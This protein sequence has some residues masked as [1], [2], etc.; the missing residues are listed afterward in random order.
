MS[1]RDDEHHEYHEEGKHEVMGRL[2][3]A[4]RGEELESMESLLAE[5]TVTGLNDFP[6][7]LMSRDSLKRWYVI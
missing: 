4:Q 7:T 6:F 3:A 2:G 1:A 5:R